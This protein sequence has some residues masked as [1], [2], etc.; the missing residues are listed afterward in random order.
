MDDHIDEPV[1]RYYVPG[2]ESAKGMVTLNGASIER[3]DGLVGKKFTFRV[4]GGSNMTKV[5]PQR[6]SRGQK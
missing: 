2:A 4:S 1:L 6:V 3:V 5:S